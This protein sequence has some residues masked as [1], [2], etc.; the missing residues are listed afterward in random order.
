MQSPSSPSPVAAV[1]PADDVGRLSLE[2]EAAL[3]RELQRAWHHVNVSHFRSV[4]LPPTLALSDN[5]SQLGLW[6][7]GSR[8][9]R[10]ELLR[11]DYHA[12]GEPTVGEVRTSCEVRAIAGNAASS[13]SG[14]YRANSVRQVAGS[15]GVEDN[16]QIVNEIISQALQRMLAD[17]GLLET[18]AR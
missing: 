11:I 7:P 6:Q 17:R 12:S 8:T 13:Y 5:S 16:E 18:L 4:L 3:L 15:P 2:L 9:L 1:S 10:V 14:N